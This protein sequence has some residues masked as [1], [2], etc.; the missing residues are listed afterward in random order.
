MGYACPVCD[1]PQADGEHLANHLAFTAML[2]GDD[3]AEFLD[4]RVDGWEDKT[5]PELAVELVPHADEAEYDEA[6]ED[7]TEGG[8]MGHGGVAGRSEPGDAPFDVGALDDDTL[9]AETERVIEEARKLFEQG[10]DAE[11]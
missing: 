3:H 11:E 1:A 6:F 10:D 4:A 5:P 2:H 8:G 9:D 7:T